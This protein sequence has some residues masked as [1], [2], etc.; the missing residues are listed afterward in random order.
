MVTSDSDKREEHKKMKKDILIVV[1]LVVLLASLIFLTIRFFN[2]KT[3]GD[4]YMAQQGKQI[5]ESLEAKDVSAV[6]SHMRA[7]ESEAASETARSEEETNGDDTGKTEEQK[8]REERLNKLNSG[9]EP[10]GPQFA[11]T[12]I[13]GDSR[14]E[15][16]ILYGLLDTS[17]IICERGADIHSIEE[18]MDTLVNLNPQNLILSYGLNDVIAYGGDVERFEENYRSILESLKANLPQTRIFINS[19]FPVRENALEKNSSFQ[20]IGDFNEALGRLCA[21]MGL[22]YID[23]SGICETYA[24]L[25]EPDGIHVSKEFYWEWMKEIILDAGL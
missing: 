15:G 18:N 1:I 11:D 19:I 10:I 6:E 9:E 5:V 22:G 12:L 14:T 3:E 4:K 13:L 24:D 16:F 7:L 2:R 21:E 17:Q 25:Y 20:Y 23:N 8:A